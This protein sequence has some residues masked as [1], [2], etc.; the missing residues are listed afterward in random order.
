M[1]MKGHIWSRLA[2]PCC[3]T[4][5]HEAEHKQQQSHSTRTQHKQHST[6]AA[7][8][9]C[10]EDKGGGAGGGHASALELPEARRAKVKGLPLGHL[11]HAALKGVEACE[12]AGTWGDAGMCSEGREQAG[13][14]HT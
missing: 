14:G 2:L 7:S 9:T 8:P 12:R 10:D 11:G 13:R 5:I 4:F 6:T 3:C 1:Q